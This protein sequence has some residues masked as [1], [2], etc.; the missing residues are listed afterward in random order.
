ML[1]HPHHNIKMFLSILN[2]GL[3]T[4]VLLLTEDYSVSTEL[5][6]AG[7]RGNTHTEVSSK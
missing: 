5:I 3:L 2:V 4:M 6:V 1:A 7:V